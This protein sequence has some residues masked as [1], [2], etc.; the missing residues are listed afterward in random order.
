MI[1]DYDLELKKVR[2]EYDIQAYKAQVLQERIKLTEILKNRS[3]VDAKM[4]ELAGKIAEKEQQ[5]KELQ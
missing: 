1:E 2:L 3:I 4:S 5:L